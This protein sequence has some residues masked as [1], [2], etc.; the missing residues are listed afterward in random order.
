MQQVL[1]GDSFKD[2]V[3]ESKELEPEHIGHLLCV[4]L[5][6]KPRSQ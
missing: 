4:W 2:L 1:V 5:S 6:T 3:L